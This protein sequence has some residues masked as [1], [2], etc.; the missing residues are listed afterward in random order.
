MF[1]TTCP[2]CGFTGTLDAFVIETVEVNNDAL[3]EAECPECGNWHEVTWQP[4]VRTFN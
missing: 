3:T 4:V 2:D 1:F